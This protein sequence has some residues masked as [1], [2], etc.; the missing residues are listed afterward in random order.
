MTAQT[1][2]ERYRSW[3]PAPEQSTDS[4]PTDYDQYQAWSN[5]QPA[6]ML[7][8]LRPVFV[9]DLSFRFAAPQRPCGVVGGWLLVGLCLSCGRCPDASTALVTPR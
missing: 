2:A 3:V 5:S 9:P 8:P 1:F 7:A 6:P 4:D